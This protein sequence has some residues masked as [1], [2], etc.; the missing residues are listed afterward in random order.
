M[1]FAVAVLVDSNQQQLTRLGVNVYSSTGV[2]EATLWT[3]C[4]SVKPKESGV[5]VK[6][7]RNEGFVVASS[8]DGAVGQHPVSST[9]YAL[10]TGYYWLAYKA[11]EECLAVSQNTLPSRPIC[12]LFNASAWCVGNASA[13]LRFRDRCPDIE[14]RKTVETLIGN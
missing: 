13:R 11:Y 9:A 2:S 10:S 6:Q 3:Q 4:S 7:R 1:P 5:V 8:R 14:L 12:C